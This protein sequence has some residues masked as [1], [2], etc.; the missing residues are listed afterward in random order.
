M[1]VVSCQKRKGY[2]ALGGIGAF[3]AAG[4]LGLSLQ[5]PAGQ[6]DQPG[7]AVF[8]VIAGILLLLASL[9][10]MWEGWKMEH[11]EKTTFPKGADL[12]RLLSLIALLLGYFLILPWLGQLI[13]STLFCIALMRV[14]STLSWPRIAAYSLIMAGALY[15]VFIYLLKVPM[16]YG[17]LFA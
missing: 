7:A 2:L 12:I 13:S 11:T 10:A 5:L 16:P 3:F 17:A 8:P 4:Y 15:A 9:A 14:L 6:L 1:T